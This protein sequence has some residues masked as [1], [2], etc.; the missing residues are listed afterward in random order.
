M[1]GYRPQVLL[2]STVLIGT[3]CATPYQPLGMSGGYT[4]FEIQDGTYYVAFEGNGFIGRPEVVQ[5]LASA[6]C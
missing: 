4:D 2:F 6:S 3:A 5:I 1:L